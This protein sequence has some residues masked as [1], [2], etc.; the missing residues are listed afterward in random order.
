MSGAGT[1]NMRRLTT[2]SQVR[3]PLATSI[4]VKAPSPQQKRTLGYQSL[5]DDEKRILDWG[6][7][8][9][10]EEFQ[11]ANEG[12]EAQLL[13][14]KLLY[15]DTLALDNGEILDILE[16]NPTLP[17]EKVRDVFLGGPVDGYTSTLHS[18]ADINY[19]EHYWKATIENER[20]KLIAPPSWSN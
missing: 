14:N 6:P 16:L 11:K 2:T 13:E 1:K 19:P 8:R 9:R 18:L 15:L 5:T 4:T 3:E 12:T 10:L 7:Q 17:W 20:E